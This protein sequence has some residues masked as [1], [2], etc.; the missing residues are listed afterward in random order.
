MGAHY[1]PISRCR[2]LHRN[3]NITTLATQVSFTPV[4]SN[5]S[6]QVTFNKE[7]LPILQ[8]DCQVCHRPGAA[9]PMSFLTYESTRPWAKAIKTA[10]L[11][12]Q[13]PPWFADPRYGDFRN[14]PKLTQADIQTLAS[15]ADSGAAEGDASHRPAD[16]QWAAGWRTQPD[17]IVKMPRPHRVPG[18][19]E[20]EIKEFFIPNPFR[21]DTW[22]TSIEIRP[23]D[24]SVVHHVI[25]Q[26]PEETFN[27]GSAWGIGGG[28]ATPPFVAGGRVPL[29]RGGMGGN[30]GGYPGR[31]PSEN[32]LSS[33]FGAFATMEAVYVPGSPPMDFQFHNS[34]KRIRGGSD[35]RIEVH[36]TPNGTATS[37][38]TMVGFTLAKGPARRRFVTMAPASLVDER[39]RIPA[40][41]SD[42]ETAGEITFN[43]D[44]EL[45]WFM[46]HMHLRGKEMTYRLLY[47]N[48]RTETVLSAKFNYN[49]QL[50]Y[51]VDELI[52]VPRGTKMVVTARYNNSA[53]NLYNP[54]PTKDVAWG[55]HTSDEMMLPWFGVIVNRDA[56]PKDIAS[57][58][59]G[60]SLR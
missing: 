55:E 14:A 25:V 57:Y 41:V 54:D 38:Q 29:R 21:D 37:D 60:G 5:Q 19:G 58:R 20:G 3:H 23:G 15:W 6:P 17:V 33:E 28:A 42:W 12:K 18:K 56:E 40:G 10:V 51:E 34:A 50:G 32:E 4:A 35:L 8:R 48:G 53:N 27:G 39:T 22:V 1:D 45:V 13:M 24:P 44:V 9:A 30:G 26:V 49:W 36:Y 16:V 7:V 2:C 59:R 11:N 31:P 47:P 43:R 46:P 52:K